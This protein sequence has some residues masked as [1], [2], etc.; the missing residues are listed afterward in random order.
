[1]KINKLKPLLIFTC[2]LF[3]IFSFS[4]NLTKESKL[5]SEILVE[6]EKEY[7]VTFTY[8]DKVI[9]TIKITP[10]SKKITLPEIIE[11]LKVK[12]GLAFTFSTATNILISNKKSIDIICGYLVDINS[13]EFLKGVHIVVL[14]SNIHTTSNSAGYF[15]IPKIDE[16]QIIQISY[17]GYPTMYLNAA[18]FL[19]NNLC[20]TISLTEK[21]EELN[22]VILQN[23]LTSGIS[24]KTDNSFVISPQEFGILPGLVEPDV[25]HQIQALPGISS[26]DETVSDINIRG[27]TNDQNLLL[28]DGIKMYHSGHF[29]GLISAFNPYLT[30]SVTVIKDGTHSQYND[31]VSGTIA[32]ESIDEIKEKPFGGAGINSL[33]ADAYAQMP[34][35]KKVSIQVSGRRAITDLWRSFTYEQYFKRA[36]QNSKVSTFLVADNKY[37]ESSSNFYFYDYSIKLLYNINEN[38]QLRFSLLNVENELGYKEAIDLE[39]ETA[40]NYKT[41]SLE[42]KNKGFGLKLTDNWNSKFKT[43][44]NA[45]YTKYNLNSSNHSLFTEQLLQQNNEVLETGLKL[46]AH[47][48]ISEKLQLLGGYHFYELGIT[49]TEV[50][51]VP[52]FSQIIKRV[53]RNHSLFSEVS[54]ISA[55]KKTFVNAGLRLNYIGTFN[56]F[57]IEPRLQALH[58]INKHFSFKIAGEFKSQNA[59]QIIDL[60]EDFLGVEKRRW[61][62]ADNKAIP[63]IK[64]KQASAGFNFHKQYVFFDIEGFYKYVDGITTANQGFQ[65]QNQYI[66]TSGSYTVKGIEFLINRKTDAFS[67]WLGYAYNHNT[68]NFPVLTPSEFPNNLDIRHSISFGNTYTYKKFNFA[69]GMLWRNGKPYTKP[70]E[71]SPI[72]ID[73]LNSYI[74]YNSPNSDNLPNYY[75]V[76]FSSTYKFNLNKKVDAMA[77]VSI[78]NIFNAK[79]ILN[80]Y[81]KITPEGAINNINNVAL[82][83]TPNFTFRVSF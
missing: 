67:T 13:K 2:L 30:E 39:T 5:L 65:N 82:G 37:V 74:N 1:M 72:T 79:N 46:N 17:M 66:K 34:I 11:Y 22:E 43:V 25:L 55:S 21:L 80:T 68:Y 31:G 64:S 83:T 57:I 4:Q 40:E 69:V 35:S 54:Y 45:Y 81:H 56:L 48:S 19:T 63:V 28:W 32:I 10:P 16:N 6:I 44:F 29:F 18:D 58:K 49:N 76:D 15:S 62:L 59:T 38:H 26:V 27:G 77:G 47:Y 36:F 41:S 23:Y 51:N 12:T 60:Q 20:L 42:Q 73:R 7:E 14:K 9:E 33:S 71:S 50:V 52:D 78:L 75:R 24:I 70:Q 8:A 3:S 61:V 53:L